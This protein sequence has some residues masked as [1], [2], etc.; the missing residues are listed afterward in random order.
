MPKHTGKSV[1][2][3][4]VVPYAVLV[5]LYDECAV[6][7]FDQLST[8][9]YTWFWINAVMSILLTTISG[10]TSAPLLVRSEGVDDSVH[11]G[12][13]WVG[14]VSGLTSAFLIAMEKV[15]DLPGIANECRFA[16]AELA[17]YLAR[18]EPMPEKIFGRIEEM[19]LMWFSHPRKCTSRPRQELQQIALGVR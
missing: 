1:D 18:K 7:R 19:R 16:R 11:I 13:S 17:H 9:F 14:L 6:Q 8:I 4:K 3:K 15:A 5:S 12:L 2:T 10:A